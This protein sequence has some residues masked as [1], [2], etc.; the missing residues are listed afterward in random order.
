[1]RRVCLG[2]GSEIPEDSDFCYSCGRWAKD[3]LDVDD[4]GNVVV[5]EYCLNC[6]E[7]LPQNSTFCPYCGYKVDSVQRPPARTYRRKLD[8]TDI[9][10]I[11]LAVI[12]GFINVFGLGQIV[13]KRWSRAFTYLCLSVL[14]FYLAPSFMLQETSRFIFLVLQLMVFIFSIQDVLNAVQRREP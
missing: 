2:C 8:R 4:R 7:A 5:T 13:L 1:M 14:L 11:I 10:A 6:N 3:A 9:L 12:P